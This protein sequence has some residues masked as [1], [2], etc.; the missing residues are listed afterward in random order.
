MGQLARARGPVSG[1]VGAHSRR[2]DVRRSDRL[3]LRRGRRIRAER[4]GRRR[5]RS[6]QPCRTA[7]GIG[8][9]VRAPSVIGRRDS[10]HRRHRCRGVSPGA[11]RLD[12]P[13]PRGC[14][15]VQRLRSP[16]ILARSERAGEH[17]GRV[18]PALG[19][20]ANRADGGRSPGA[21][22]GI[23]RDARARAANG[24]SRRAGRVRRR[25]GRRNEARRIA[26]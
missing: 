25:R 8:T 16:E 5:D 6:N 19:R 21:V 2:R 20:A 4:C 22:T 15:R 18:H 24:S 11:S 14:A 1:R 17:R 10:V 7:G 23:R 26:R 3:A 13:V 12:P 9:D